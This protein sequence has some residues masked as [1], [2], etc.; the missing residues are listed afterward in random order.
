MRGSNLHA[1]VCRPHTGPFTSMVQYGDLRQSREADCSPTSVE[2]V[3]ISTSGRHRVTY[4]RISRPHEL[5]ESNC[6]DRT[7]GRS[8]QLKSRKVRMSSTGMTTDP[9]VLLFDVGG[10]L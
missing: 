5:I 7:D 10:V 9:S 1:D 2:G 6:R 8:A 4:A 3:S